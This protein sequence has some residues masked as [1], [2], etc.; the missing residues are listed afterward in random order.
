MDVGSSG[1]GIRA[2]GSR[3]K[4]PKPEAQIHTVILAF[5]V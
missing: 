3:V 1:E 4:Q 2:Q 5:G